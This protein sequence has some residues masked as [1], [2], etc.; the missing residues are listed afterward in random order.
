MI[1]HPLYVLG[2]TVSLGLAS[3][4]DASLSGSQTLIIAL[5]V[6]SL[7]CVGCVTFSLLPTPLRPAVTH[8]AGLLGVLAAK[9]TEASLVGQQPSTVAGRVVHRQP[10]DAGRRSSTTSGVASG[11][12][13]EHE[14]RSAL[15]R[16]R[17]TSSA[18]LGAS[19][20]PTN[21]HQVNQNSSGHKVR[22]TSLPAL[23]ANKGHLLVQVSHFFFSKIYPYFLIVSLDPL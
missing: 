19:L 20:H 15:V 6:V 11:S 7:R 2:Y 1:L 21:Q 16:K 17:R 13:S 22:R 3:A 23:L 12:S 8:L 14:P 18:A 9:F 5:A 4:L 10:D